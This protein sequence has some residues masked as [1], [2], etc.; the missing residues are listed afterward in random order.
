MIHYINSERFT[1]E[2]VKEII[3]QNMQLALSEDAIKRIEKC[4]AYLDNKM[5]TQKE[6]IYGVT[7]GFGSLC[8]ISVSKQELSQL[9][10][11]LALLLKL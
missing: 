10:K 1:I 2:R 8:N 3:A 4:R 5:E 11:N 9:Q 7:T 6:P